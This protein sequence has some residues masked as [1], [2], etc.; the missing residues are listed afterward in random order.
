VK[1]IERERNGERKEKKERKEAEG[2]SQIFRK[3]G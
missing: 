2:A 3:S 1:E